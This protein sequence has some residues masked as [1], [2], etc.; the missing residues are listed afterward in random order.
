MALMVVTDFSLT[1]TAPSREEEKPLASAGAAYPLN[2]KTVSFTESCYIEEI[3][4]IYPACQEPLAF[5]GVLCTGEWTFQSS[6]AW[7]FGPPGK[8]EEVGGAGVPP[9]SG[10]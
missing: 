6:R 5:R 3:M 9:A 10:A 1:G 8:H 4:S 2:E 7:A